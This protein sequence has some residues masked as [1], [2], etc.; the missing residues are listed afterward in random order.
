MFGHRADGKL[1]KNVGPIFKIMP[2]IMKKRSDSQVYYRQDISLESLDEYINKK[3][4]EG[5][6]ISYMLILYAALVRII[7]EKPRLNRFVVNGKVYERNSID[8]SLVVKKE[9]S[10]NVEETTTKLH[11]DGSENILAVK[12]KLEEVIAQNKDMSNKNSTDK[13][14]KIFSFIP[15]FIVRF[16]VNFLM[17][18]DRHEMLPKSIVELSPFHTSAFITNVGSIGID[19]IYHHIYDFGT[20]SLFLSMGKKKKGLIYGDDEI[21]EHKII[22]IALV[23]DERICDGFY[24]AT[25]IK[26][27]NKYL[28]KPDLLEETIEPLIKTK[29]KKK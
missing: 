13:F 8:I 7:S 6:N 21:K 17:F 16:A 24:F 26:L 27:L 9:M 11:F 5:I 23:A 14:V 22:S 18:L 25:A 4:E 20:T 3:K 28:K 2:H 29:K 15:N 19:T 1:A 12:D 10:E